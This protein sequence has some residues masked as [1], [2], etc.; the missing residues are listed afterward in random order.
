[1]LISTQKHVRSRV[2]AI[3][4]LFVFLSLCF[5][6]HV[7]A[8]VPTPSLLSNGLQSTPLS[9]PVSENFALASDL[10]EAYFL[11]P[12]DGSKH[13]IKCQKVTD[14]DFGRA[15]SGI[16]TGTV[17]MDPN[18]AISRKSTG[19]VIL[20]NRNI[21][22]PAHIQLTI[23]NTDHCEGDDH[24]TSDDNECE[25]SEDD[26][27]KS[28]DESTTFNRHGVINNISLPSSTT[29]SL[30]LNSHTYTMTAD[31]YKFIRTNGDFYIGATLHVG[32]NQIAGVYTGTF[33]V[34]QTCN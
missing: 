5:S 29:L 20:D 17:I 13:S 10:S 31:T 2:R 16:T 8:Q 28:D 25:R 34:T 3:T 9:S 14:L 24:C 26:D 1:M 23:Y 4:A 7:F 18:T 30:S 11:V 6:T 27:N 19:G 12:D 22:H 33:S 32:A 21:G 15:F